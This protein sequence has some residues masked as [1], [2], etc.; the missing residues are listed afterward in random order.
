M[1]NIFET[2]V[3]FCAVIILLLPYERA[4]ASS[5]ITVLD[6]FSNV[7]LYNGM[8]AE[9]ERMVTITDT[10]KPGEFHSIAIKGFV[11]NVQ[12]ETIRVKGSVDTEIMDL[13]LITVQ[14]PKENSAAYK[15]KMSELKSKLDPL[16]TQLQQ[17]DMESTKLE[18]RLKAAQSYVSDAFHVDVTMATPL[19]SKRT[20]SEA[21][22]IMDFLDRESEKYHQGMLTLNGKRTALNEQIDNISRQIEHLKSSVYGKG[23]T[24]YRNGMPGHPT[25]QH[26]MVTE[27]ELTFRTRLARAVNR[28]HPLTFNITY[29]SQT[30]SWTPEYDIRIEQQIKPA[31]TLTGSTSG[32]AP[33]KYHMEIDYFA[34]VW[35]RTGEHWIDARLTLSTAAP[36]YIRSHPVPYRHGVQIQVSF[37]FA[38]EW[39]SLNSSLLTLQ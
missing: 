22:E 27:K 15:L 1:F 37:I 29:M 18:A 14:S 35:Q 36:G 30:A 23:A 8:M 2:M 19:S 5:I 38:V 6:K 4:V 3:R 17:L 11:R 28:E 24:M 31:L 26:A 32:T 12:E 16:R 33:A 13:K 7:V 21:T 25:R 10:L 9:V 39:I 34:N 20:I